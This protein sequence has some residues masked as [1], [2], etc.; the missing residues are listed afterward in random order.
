[1]GLKIFLSGVSRKNLFDLSLK[2]SSGRWLIT[3]A[4]NGN[5]TEFH[6][7]I[8]SNKPFLQIS[9]QTIWWIYSG[10][11]QYCQGFPIQS[12]LCTKQLWEC[13]QPLSLGPIQTEIGNQHSQECDEFNKKYVFSRFLS[14]CWREPCSL[15]LSKSQLQWNQSLLREEATLQSLSGTLLFMLVFFLPAFYPGSELLSY[16]CHSWD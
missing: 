1:M 15:A 2:T 12:L 7:T 11:G 6:S 5:H 4:L 8:T 14:I 3:S 16:T 10:K 9:L 13:L